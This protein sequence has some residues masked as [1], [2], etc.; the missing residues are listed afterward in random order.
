MRPRVPETLTKGPFDLAQALAQ[1]LTKRQLAGS[2]WRR[3]GPR[4]YVARDLD[5]DRMLELKAAMCRLPDVAVFSGSTAAFL[6]GLD[7]RCGAIEATLPSPTRISRRAGITLKRRRLA[8]HEVVL[9][10]GFR[11][12]SPLRTVLDL[13]SRLDLVEAVAVLDAALHRQLIRAEQL[14]ARGRLDR[15][16]E[17]TEPKTES[18]METRL[19]L[20]LV[21]A[22]LPRPQVQV[23][24]RDESGSFLGRPDLY[25]PEHRLAIEYD[26]A[27]HRESLASDNR[28]QN[29]LLDAGYRVLRFTASDVLGSP[30][31]VIGLV[32][33]ASCA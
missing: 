17:L 25:Y 15:A 12:T 11:V 14:Q 6:H 31:S 4:T 20:L 8:P 33:R 26:G 30:A 16:I 5:E 9:R 1:G 3:I 10:N 21:L 13:A 24:L 28:R 29:R 2:A 32:R 27:T 7:A 22:G 23:V 18:P 19:R